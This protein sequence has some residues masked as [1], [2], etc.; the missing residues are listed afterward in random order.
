MKILALL[1]FLQSTVLAQVTDYPIKKID[2]LFKNGHYLIGLKINSE[3][4]AETEYTKTCGSVP[5]ALFKSAELSDMLKDRS[6]TYSYLHRALSK[7]KVCQD[8]SVEWLAT[9]YLGGFFFHKLTRDS[10]LYYLKKSYNKIQSKNRPREISSVTGMLGEVL[11]QLFDNGEESIPY[12][13]ISVQNAEASGDYKSLGYAYL[14]YGSF[15]AH[16][17]NCGEGM[18]MVEKSYEI[19]STNKDNEGLYW[20]RYIL[21]WVYANCNRT[22][23]AYTL[24]RN[25]INQLDSAYNIETARHTAYYQTLYE[26]AT[27]EKENLALTLQIETEARQRKNLIVFFAITF[28]LI[29]AIFILI[30]RQYSMKKKVEL[31]KNLQTERERISRE[32]HD[33][34]GTKLSQVASTLDWMNNSTRPIA[35]SEKKILLDSGLNTTKDAIHDLREAIWAMKKSD[36]NFVDFADKLKT[37]LKHFTNPDKNILISFHEKLNEAVLSPQEGLDLLRICQEALSNALTHSQCSKI[38]IQ[39]ESDANRYHIII[40][41]N[42]VGFDPQNQKGEHYG[43]KNMEHRAKAI[44]AVLKITTHPGK[45]TTISVTK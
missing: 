30:Y 24:L 29:V 16:H 40:A 33:N 45:G 11:N 42:G 10:A 2:S 37:S 13:K 34:I 7:A 41:D 21:S 31:E 4:L 35:E 3:Y 26:T 36:I 38:E 20:L 23:E 25:H 43:L 1:L 12:Y 32:L 6:Q 15:L 14:R 5:L 17:G 39:L 44:G 19:F 9:R 27:K 28:V 22:E 18:P 8:D